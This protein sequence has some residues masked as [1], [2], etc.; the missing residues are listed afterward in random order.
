[1]STEYERIKKDFFAGRIKGCKAYFLENNYYVEAAY[2]KIILDKLDDA[3]ELF[4]KEKDKNSRANWGLFLLQLLKGD[5]K[6]YPTYFELRNFLE[7][8]LNMLILY[9]KGDYVEKII[10]YADYMAYYNPECYKFIGRAFWANNL[11]SAAM[12]YLRRAKDKFYQDPELHY[13][14]GYIYFTI[15]KDMEKCRK[16]LDT[17]LELL[18]EY[19][20]AL[21]LYKKLPQ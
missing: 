4:L 13:L 14:L 1:M 15:D 3:Q 10:R 21:A 11:I 12:F 2:C 7:I 8:D 16:A 18:P 9:C 19:A 20:P 17:C 5:I 6:S